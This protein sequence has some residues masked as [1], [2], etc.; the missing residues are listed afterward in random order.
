MKDW[1][2]YGHILLAVIVFA[3]LF[4]IYFKPQ[5]NKLT[6][7]K[8]EREKTEAEVTNLKQRNLQLSKIEG[9]LIDLRK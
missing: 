3:L 7:L 1:P 8:E 4:F 6:T 2:W 9:E 5:N